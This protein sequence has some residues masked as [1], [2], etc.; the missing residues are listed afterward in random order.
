MTTWHDGVR[1]TRS[2]RPL[3]MAVDMPGVAGV[4]GDLCRGN[5]NSGTS[6]GR[7]HAVVLIEVIMLAAGGDEDCS[8]EQTHI[9]RLD[10]VQS[11]VGPD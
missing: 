2:D 8:K 3:A 10:I 1:L 4:G 9:V 7:H 6:F 5:Q 11:V